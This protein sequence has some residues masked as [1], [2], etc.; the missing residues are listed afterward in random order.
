MADK[1][2]VQYTVGYDNPNHIE[3]HSNAIA[4]MAN[5]ALTNVSAVFDKKFTVP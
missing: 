4:G 1:W 2:V 3:D 5:L